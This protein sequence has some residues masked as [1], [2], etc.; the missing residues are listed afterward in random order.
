MGKTG[1]IITCPKD[2]KKYY[3]H[4]HCHQCPDFE[5]C[6]QFPDYNEKALK[7]LNM[8]E[9]F[10]LQ[11]QR[12]REDY[13]YLD[14]MPTEGWLW[15]FIR[16]SSTYYSLLT[17]LSS[18][19]SKLSKEPV[20]HYK[21]WD[22]ELVDCM[23]RLARIGLMVLITEFRIWD[24]NEE[25]YVVVPFLDD[26]GEEVCY[27]YPREY[28]RYT[29][30]ATYDDGDVEKTIVRFSDPIKSFPHSELNRLA[31]GASPEEI[32]E[33]PIWE[34]F[35]RMLSPTRTEKT[36]YVGISLEAKKEDIIRHLSK[37]LDHNLTPIE[38]RVRDKKW[39]TYLMVYDLKK[40]I[41]T[42]RGVSDILRHAYPDQDKFEKL[43]DEKN[44]ENYWKQ[45]RSLIDK[46]KYL[47]FFPPVISDKE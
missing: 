13:T 15:E 30:L 32:V 16:R 23:L 35:L 2:G 42:Y 18:L 8:E 4:I 19:V 10:T 31:Q 29:D 34:R 7:D 3:N 44:I 40:E 43:W 1:A 36:L 47:K 41:S 22:K 9:Q 38:G 33:E 39:K 26:N 12:I 37:I 11:V 24:G 46:G 45:A 14:E 6:T 20:I 27:A 28:L 25:D 21:N 5:Q 17:E